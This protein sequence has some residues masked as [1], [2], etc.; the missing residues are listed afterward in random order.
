MTS[1]KSHVG[2]AVWGQ[3]NDVWRHTLFCFYFIV[4]FYYHNLHREIIIFVPS[5]EIPSEASCWWSW[6]TIFS[7]FETNP[8]PLSM[9]IRSGNSQK[10]LRATGR[11]QGEGVMLAN[12]IFSQKWGKTTKQADFFSTAACNLF[13]RQFQKKSFKIFS[14]MITLLWK[15]IFSI[16]GYTYLEIPVQKNT[17]W[18]SHCIEW[19][20]R[21]VSWFVT[22]APNR[23][24]EKF[25]ILLWS[26]LCG[27]GQ[28]CSNSHT[29]LKPWG[30]RRWLRAKA[31]FASW[32]ANY[33]TLALA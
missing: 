9:V 17:S 4:F 10:Q 30:P 23:K 18:E 32:T 20:W 3:P 7:S 33:L 14:A 27:P 16:L 6:P 26:S 22:C 25:K 15:R 11:G 8:F 28:G 29:G 31:R 2:M 24:K 1:F 21:F 13:R 12:T 5:K 19:D